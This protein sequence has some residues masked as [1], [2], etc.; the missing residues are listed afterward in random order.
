VDFGVEGEVAVLDF[1]RGEG[2]IRGVGKGVGT[3]LKPFA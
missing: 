2:N 1:Q 3:G